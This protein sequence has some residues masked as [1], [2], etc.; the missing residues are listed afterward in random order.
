MPREILNDRRGGHGAMTGLDTARSR[1]RDARRSLRAGIVCKLP[2]CAGR[3]SDARHEPSR[4]HASTT[5]YLGPMTFVGAMPTSG[6]SDSPRLSALRPTAN[7]RPA[8][9]N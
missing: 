6:A 1:I 5:G 2:T 9:R 8:A 3:A 4:T 7:R